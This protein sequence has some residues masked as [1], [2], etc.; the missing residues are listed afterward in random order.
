[1]STDSTNASSTE[2]SNAADAE[3]AADAARAEREPDAA[4]EET[5]AEE[6][7]AEETAAEE[8]A[9]EETAAEE[10]AGAAGPDGGAEA[11]PDLDEIGDL[12]LEEQ[13]DVLR[14]KVEALQQERD[15][16]DEKVLR[17]SADFQNYRR[18]MEREKR[19]RF[20]SGK[21]E[22]V[23][24]MLEVLDDFERSVEAADDLGEAQDLETAY[25]SLKGGVEMV[26]EKFQDQL[27]GLGVE[28]IEAEGRP[29]DE[30]VHEAMMRQPTDDAAPGEVLHE[31]RKGYR[32]GERVIRHSR[33]VVAAAP[34]DGGEN[35]AE[36]SGGGDA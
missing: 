2:S 32:M 15:E 30:S 1:V 33:V 23:R 27:Q 5:A 25:E 4:A 14:R 34:N 31:V 11:L 8:T 35:G 24:A 36:S 21:A 26:F 28:P 12:A 16:L 9:A 29:F 17:K 10:T 18:R 19:R 6:T 3:A 20:Q 22:V 13:V 7:A